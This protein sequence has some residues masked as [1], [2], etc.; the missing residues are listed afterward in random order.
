MLRWQILIAAAAAAWFLFRYLPSALLFVWPGLLRTRETSD[1]GS[2]DPEREPAMER[3]HKGLTE[4]GFARV[5]A[6]QVSPPLSAGWAELVYAAPA[7]RAFADVDA[8]GGAI[9]VTLLTPFEGGQAVLTSDYRRATIDRPDYLAG[10]LPGSD[11]PALWAAHRRRVEH[12]HPP[13][14]EAQPWTDFS[15]TGRVRA[16]EV[17]TAGSGR[18]ELRQRSA[19]PLMYVLLA[20]ALL[21]VSALQL[22]RQVGRG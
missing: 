17:V 5:G 13:G 11:I 19:A 20:L 16:D 9:A 12:F 10:G 1:D 6:I 22:V 8:R 14:G 15:I 21:T 3:V 18:G 7:Q 2:L 4:L